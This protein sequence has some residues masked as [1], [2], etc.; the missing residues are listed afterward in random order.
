MHILTLILIIT[1]I[2]TVGTE[3]EPMSFS[4]PADPGVT[5]AACEAVGR[6]MALDLAKKPGVASVGYACMDVAMSE[7]I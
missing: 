3:Q 7:A 5:Q 6:S 1:H 4:I 2:Q